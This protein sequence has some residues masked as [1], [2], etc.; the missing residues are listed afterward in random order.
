MAA[1]GNNVY[2][3]TSGGVLRSSDDGGHWSVINSGLTNPNVYAL[4]AIGNDLYAGTSGGG[5][6]RSTDDGDNWSEVNN[7]LT[8]NVCFALASM[9]DGSGDTVLFAGTGGSGVFQTTDHGANWVHASGGLGLNYL[10]ALAAVGPN[11]F[12]AGPVNGIFVSSDRGTSWTAAST[13]LLN[14]SVNA[15]IAAP[16][17]SLGGT[18]LAGT[19]YGSAWRRPLWQMISLPVGY[20]VRKGW[21]LV[22]LPLNV[23][24]AHASVLYPTA[25]SNCFAYNGT[26]VV[27]ETLAVGTGYWEKFDHDH[28]IP[29]AGTTVL[30]DTV[31]LAPGWNLIGS[32]SVP[33][34]VASIVS[35]PPSMTMS[36]FFSYEGAYSTKDTLQ[37]GRGY[38]VKAGE[39]GEIVLQQGSTA[40]HVGHIRIIAGTELPPTPPGE[41]VSDV[42]SPPTFALDAA[43]PNPFNPVTH[44]RYEIAEV[45][46]VRLAIYDVVGRLVEV[47]VDATEPA[48]AMSV[49]WDAS[50]NASG[51]YIC[52]IEVSPNGDIS[53]TMSR[54]NKII[55]MR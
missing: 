39:A 49:S 14:M 40:A 26:Y 20:A 5:V 52:R 33:V 12:A 48:G 38:W 25:I 45:S 28:R 17:T 7:G 9:I 50:G 15:L 34:L 30:S 37:P 41:P 47:L 10:A 13:G 23:D 31:D 35:D 22:S 53:R 8:N 24:D 55:Y 42:L 18:L 6:F 54:S 32:I 16:D 27:A 2:A 44:I 43:Y 21:N 11:I 51:V 19:L 36:R 3:G 4:L 46:R 1:K 29:I